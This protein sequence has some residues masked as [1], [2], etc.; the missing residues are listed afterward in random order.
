MQHLQIHLQFVTISHVLNHSHHLRANPHQR[1][2]LPFTSVELKSPN[3]QDRTINSK[4]I[5]H[6]IKLH[7]NTT[8]TRIY[9]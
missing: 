5:K 8:Q 4:I 3:V 7:L 9:Y 6:L 2:L 1:I